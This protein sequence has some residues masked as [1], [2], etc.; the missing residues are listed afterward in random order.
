MLGVQKVLQIF[1]NLLPGLVLIMQMQRLTLMGRWYSRF[2]RS[3]FSDF[4]STL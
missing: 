2:F 4:T 3:Y 1:I